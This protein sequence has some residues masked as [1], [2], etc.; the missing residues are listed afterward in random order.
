[1]GNTSRCEKT[2]LRYFLLMRQSDAARGTKW[3]KT[4]DGL[5]IR[6]WSVESFK[7]QH[8]YKELRDVHTIIRK[9]LTSRSTGR[10]LYDTRCLLWV[11]FRLCVLINQIIC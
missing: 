5:V 4:R 1:M 7:Q 6:E 3:V 10:R 2:E 9:T 11:Y 8:I